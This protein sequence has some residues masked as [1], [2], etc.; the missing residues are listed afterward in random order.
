[1]QQAKNAKSFVICKQSNRYIGW[2]TVAKT[3]DGRILVAFSGDRDEH[4]CPYGKTFLVHSDDMGNSWSEPVLI[5]NTPLD[6]RDAGILVLKSGVIVI[7]WFTSLAFE[8]DEFHA[9]IKDDINGRCNHTKSAWKETSAKIT[10]LERAKWLGN[11][12]RR[13]MDGGKTWEEPVLTAVTAPHGPVQ[14]TDGRLLYVGNLE[15]TGQPANRVCVEESRDEGKRWKLIGEITLPLDKTIEF[16]EPHACEVS[17]D[18]II[19]VLRKNCDVEKR[20]MYQTESIDGGYTWSQPKEIPDKNA[21]P[22]KGYPPHLLK[23]QDGRILLS[24]GYRLEPFGERAL[25]SHD[26]G[27]TW[28]VENE[29]AISNAPNGDL[30]YPSSI[31][32][33]DGRVLTVYYQADNPGE[34]PCLM[35]TIWQV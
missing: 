13:S 19:V 26:K 28:D 27:E 34:M 8:I 29:I 32:L 14:L 4:I 3:A 12:T 22:I 9:W 33:S 6:D 31:E 35:G 1:M 7:S 23:L 10:N 25:M 21:L 17:A 5:N 16:C 18:K 11:W 20:G 2:P 24:Y 15:Y 30:G